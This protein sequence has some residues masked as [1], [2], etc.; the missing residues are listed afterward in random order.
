M[1]RRGA[2]PI[3]DRRALALQRYNNRGAELRA[4]GALP[5]AR[6][7]LAM[8]LQM[9]RRLVAAWDSLGVLARRQGHARGAEQDDAT[10]LAID[11]AMPPPSPTPPAC[12]ALGDR[13]ARRRCRHGCDACN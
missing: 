10:A 4:D 5:A 9:D 12:G 3:S 13:G 8:A 1:E 7:H 2:Q 11:P 6:Q